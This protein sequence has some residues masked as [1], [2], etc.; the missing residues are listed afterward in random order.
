MVRRLALRRLF[1]FSAVIGLMIGVGVVHTPSAEAVEAEYIYGIHD[2]GGEYLMGSNKGWIV[3][4][5]AIGSNPNDFGGEN[6]SSYSNNGYGVIVRINNGYGSSG[7]L[8][9]QSQYGNWAT[10]A[11][12]YIAASSGVDYWIIANEPNL[13]R[14]WPGNNHGDPATGEP[15]TVA[16]YI[17]AYN[18][19]W[20]AVK[21]A[22]PSAKLIPAPVGTWA[23]PYPAQG[24]DPFDDYHVNI[25][26]GIAASRID[27]LAIHAYTH[28]CD[29]ALVTS[30]QLMGPPYQDI[31]FQFRVYKDL[32]QR[33]PS[34]LSSKNV[35][36]TECDQNVEC[37]T[38]SAPKQT[39]LNQNNGW[40]KAVYAEINAWN[41]ANSQKIRTVAMFRWEAA[42]EGEWTFSWSNLNG[43]KA[44]FQ[45]A[46]AFGYKWGTSGG[47]S[48]S[49]GPGTP[50]GSNLSQIAAHYIE[51]GRN[52]TS[53][54]GRHAL[55]G[56]TG[57]KWTANISQSGNVGTL[58]V[59]LGA[60]STVTG[61]VVRHAESGGEAKAL[62][63]QAF[64]VQSASSPQG[65]WTTEWTQDN[66]CQAAFNT[67]QYGTP[68]SLRYLRLRITD[69]GTDT[70]ARIPEFEIYGTPG[71]M[72]TITVQAEDFSGGVNA[73]QGTDYN[74]TTTGNSG[75]Q[76]RSTNV[77]IETST[78]GL[79]NVGWVAANEW[80]NY[81]I[82]GDG[83]D[84]DITVRYA[85]PN[86]GRQMHLQLDGQPITAT[87]SL[88]NTGGWQ[89]WQ[90]LNAGTVNL[91]TGWK[92]LT[93][94]C[95]NDSFNV[96]RIIFTPSTG[97]GG[98][99]T[100]E[101]PSG[102]NLSLAATQVAVSAQ[103]DANNGGNKA[104]DGVTSSGSKWTSDGSAMPEWL[105]L[106]LG[107]N[108]TVNGF[109]VRHA[110]AGGEAQY[111]NTQAFSIQSS[112]TYNGP[113]VDETVVDNT[114]QASVTNRKYVTPKSL[115]YIRL[116][117]TDAG[118]D[119]YVR[120]PEFE[121]IGS[122]GGGGGPITVAEDFNSVP[123][124]TS[125]FDAGWGS[126]ATWSSVGGG[127]SGNA[128]Q[129][130]RGSQGSSA[131]VKVYSI[132]ASTNYTISIYIKAP[133]SANTYWAETAYRLGSHTASDFDSNAG[134]W[135]MVKKF[136]NSGENGNGNTWTQ[137]SKTFNS[138]SNT[139]IS[140]GYKLGSSGAGGPTILWDTLRVN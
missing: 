66:T 27:A 107:S 32:M 49:T 47:G 98:G 112:T 114:A 28:G 14:E 133:S 62:N 81:P 21:G 65:T 88:N 100:D 76:Y 79:Y 120:L 71:A 91:G 128:L 50:S 129:A 113:W 63:T 48:C 24:I 74:D 40:T 108:K 20:T 45:D 8:P 102:T 61:Y 30:E 83:G 72:G 116:H 59:D 99:M 44:D 67:F 117:I 105:K 139:Q 52:L 55:D 135:T 82:Q 41:Q 77:D 6:F 64:T 18:Q 73:A 136:E 10:R 124:W 103:Y 106:D 1:G 111:F 109:I 127:Q 23:P 35:Y 80:L 93:L 31:H 78:D 137:Y 4:T 123:S 9:V 53:Q 17:S 15:I 26:N 36:M 110:Q 122:S 97:G 56:N 126:A 57:T 7:T 13:P 60:T 22:V 12:N 58:V 101:V 131:K 138:G 43:V 132:T 95:N 125:S 46:V 104:I 90:T 92:T 69:A 51:S 29:P 87:L 3:F 39:W 34:A 84:F 134:A 115:R 54:V 96:N 38:G 118:I 130:A 42:T 121:V 89:N 140:V 70:W 16:R 85:T 37:A 19:T 94:F 2:P 119:N 11:K 25:L 68:K 75:G 33:I 5:R 86:N